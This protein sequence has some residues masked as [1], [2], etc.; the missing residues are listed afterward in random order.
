M[1]LVATWEQEHNASYTVVLSYAGTGAGIGDAITWPF[2][3]SIP[4]SG[5]RNTEN[6]FS[7][8]V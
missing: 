6:L 2:V 4:L 5:G 7:K 8:S 1:L 3:K